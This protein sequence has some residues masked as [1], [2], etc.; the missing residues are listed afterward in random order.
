MKR[1]FPNSTF[2]REI[3]E[4]CEASVENTFRQYAVSPRN[5]R[6]GRSLGFPVGRSAGGQRPQGH[7]RLPAQRLRHRH[8]PAQGRQRLPA[9]DRQLL[10]AIRARPETI[11]AAAT[12]LALARYLESQGGPPLR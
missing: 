1:A 6:G 9:A 4:S 10:L 5:R 7:G 8:R 3:T 11:A 2:V 12:G